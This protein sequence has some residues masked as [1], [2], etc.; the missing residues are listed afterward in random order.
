MTMLE[1]LRAS[2]LEAGVAWWTSLIEAPPDKDTALVLRPYA[3]A[4]DQDIP[5][6]RQSVQ[7]LARAPT[8]AESEAMSWAA[9]KAILAAAPACDR[10]VLSIVP[11][12]EPFFMD[13][14]DAGRYR[15]V[16]NFD[17]LATHEGE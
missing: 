1:A 9:Y 10:R 17:V 6:G 2:L 7:C 14:D 12:Q 11:R 13:R 3:S 15:H 8:F 4:A 16:F 5:V